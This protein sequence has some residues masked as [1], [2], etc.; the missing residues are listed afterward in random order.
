MYLLQFYKA[1]R[2]ISVPVSKWPVP[3]LKPGKYTISITD[4]S[5]LQYYQVLPR[6]SCRIITCLKLYPPQTG[7]LF[8]L[9]AV[10]QY[11][12][13]HSWKDLYTVANI[14]YTS[15]QAVA[16]TLGLFPKD[17]KAYFAITEAINTSYLPGQL[18][19]LFAS[20]LVDIPTDIPKL[21]ND[22][23]SDMTW[24]LQINLTEAE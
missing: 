12:L 19:F 15:F 5:T 8:Y 16:I 2:I 13:G 17:S 4:C 1:Y 24:D 23:L 14:Q 7:K 21:Y 3:L 18:Q 20:I 22:F 11:Y 6:G 9:C 10:L